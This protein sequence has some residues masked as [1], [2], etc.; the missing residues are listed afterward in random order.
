MMDPLNLISDYYEVLVDETGDNTTSEAGVQSSEAAITPVHPPIALR[1]NSVSGR[2]RG[3]LGGYEL[4]LRVDVDA[5]RPSNLVSGDYYSHSGGVKTYFGSFKSGTVSATWSSASVV[6][7]GTLSTTWST[8]YKVVKITIPRTTIFSP[9]AAA[10]IIYYNSA[11]GQGA[12]YLCQFESVYFRNVRLEEDYEQGTSLFGS[13]NTGTLPHGGTART[14]DV[15]SSYAEAGIQIAPTGATNVV[16][17]AEA[18]TNAVWTNAELEAA[19][20]HH[21]SIVSD[22]PQWQT[23]LLACKSKHELTSGGSTL[24]GIMFDYSGTFQRQGC[25]VFQ[26]QVNSYYG[27]AGSNDANRHTLY[28]Y[29]H[30]LGHSFNLLHSWDKGRPSSLSWM[31]YDWKY[32]QLHGAG[33]FWA[34]FAFQ[35]DDLELVHLRHDYRNSVI[36]GGDNWAVN[37]GFGTG[38]ERTDITGA[39]IENRSGLALDLTSKP[40]FALGEP[41]VVDLRLR[42]RDL[43]GKMVNALLHPN[44]DVTKIVIKK[45]GGEV[46]AYEPLAEHLCGPH[47]VTLS[48]TNPSISDSAY[49]GYGKGGNYFDQPGTYTLRAGYFTPEGGVVSSSDLKIRVRSPLSSQEDEIAE[50]Y[51]GD[52]QGRL[53]YL[54]GSDA[55][56]LQKGNDAFALVLDKYADEPLSVYAALVQGVNAS[57]DFKMVGPGKKVTIRKGD[58]KR[59]TELIGKVFASSRQGKG[60]DHITLGYAMGKAAESQLKGGDKKA[61]KKTTDDMK[62]FLD[63]LKLEKHEL[64]QAQAKMNMFSDD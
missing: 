47:M 59:A 18:G 8:T 58:S 21:F 27:G 9:R 34:N 33:S 24:F 29:V 49:I 64:R 62:S 23:Y 22:S 12:T 44:F 61:A 45:P 3:T 32:D 42:L 11:G 37:A 54:L 36:M 43:N 55:P 53:F 2:Y 15:V 13:Y 63:K 39:M 14:L 60:V 56:H 25:A 7:Q 20:H 41:V 48:E 51:I 57:R 4:E 40:V 16:P 6:I 50:L 38:E 17:T 19:M 31:N 30:E 52:E 35:F 5:S 26:T 10:T 28:C 1:K 46:V